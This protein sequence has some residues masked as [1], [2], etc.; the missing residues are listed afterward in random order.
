[1]KLSD[2]LHKLNKADKQKLLEQPESGMGYQVIVIPKKPNPKPSDL[3]IISNGKIVQY[4]K[5]GEHY[6]ILVPRTGK[7]FRDLKKILSQSNSDPAIGDLN[8]GSDQHSLILTMQAL[9]NP[10]IKNYYHS[11]EQ[12]E[13]SSKPKYL[14]LTRSG[15][16][17]RRLSPFR[18]DRRINKDGSVVEGTFATTVS[19]LTV[20]PSG[21]AA[22]GRYALPNRFSASYVY[23]II[24]PPGTKVFFGTVEPNYGLSGGGVEVYFPEGCGEG[25][26]RLLGTI[27]EM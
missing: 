5:H 8:I 20:V 10:E 6:A 19:D 22:V 2:D 9:K 18:D 17:F 3:I 14:Y 13:D 4:L 11:I 1:M 16:E 12:K 7:Y 27:P 23:Q 15:D 24:P 26:A 21:I 25:S